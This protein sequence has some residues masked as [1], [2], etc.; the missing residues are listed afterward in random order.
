MKENPFKK[1]KISS[2]IFKN[3]IFL[4][5]GWGESVA[6]GGG[7][8]LCLKCHPKSSK[9][10]AIVHLGSKT[11]ITKFSLKG[12]FSRPL[13]IVFFL[14]T[15]CLFRMLILCTVVVHWGPY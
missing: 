10:G 11:W 9:F 15:K 4:F 12:P 5:K 14:N 7:G 13:R 3:Y 2:F 6:W 8:G 1:V